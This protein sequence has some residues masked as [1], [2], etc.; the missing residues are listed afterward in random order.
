MASIPR[1]A[2]LPSDFPQIT[3]CVFYDDPRSSMEWLAKAFGFA[4]RVCVSDGAGAVVHAEMELGAGVIQVG[5]AHDNLR[6]PRSLG[7]ACTQSVCVYVADVDARYERA[8]AAGARIYLELSD[9]EYGDRSF[10]AFDCEGHLW[11]FAQRVD[12]GAWERS[13]ADHRVTA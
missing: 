13:T 2:A 12:P 5:P 10:G 7:G 8:R 1:E 4:T 3:P 9:K 6:S 11:W